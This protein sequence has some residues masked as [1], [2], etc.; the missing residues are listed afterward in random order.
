MKLFYLDNTNG[1]TKIQ[2]VTKG[3][4]FNVVVPLETSNFQKSVMVW[5]GI[6]SNGKTK[7]R[8]IKPGGKI[9][10]SY[11]IKH[12][13]KPFI[14]YDVPRLYPNGNYIFYQD[15]APSHRSTKTLNYLDEKNIRYVTPEQWLPHSPDCAPCDYFLWGYL[16]NCLKYKKLET[17]E[18]MKKVLKSVYNKVPQEMIERALRSWPKRYGQIYYAKGH[19]IE[20]TSFYH[21]QK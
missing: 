13:L 3:E 21:K 20:K 8:F 4:K 5:A 15:S 17:I 16:K 10:A 2:Y 11:Y 7:L 14:R 18:Q 6:C 12:V 1:Q 9:Y 19:Q